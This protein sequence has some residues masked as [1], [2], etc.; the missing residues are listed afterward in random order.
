MSLARLFRHLPWDFWGWGGEEEGEREGG[1]RRGREKRR[2]W[3]GEEKGKTR[4]SSLAE[5]LE[6]CEPGGCPRLNPNGAQKA[7]LREGTRKAPDSRDPRGPDTLLAQ[8]L[9]S[10]EPRRSPFFP[11]LVQVEFPSLAI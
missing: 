6:K 9:A 5:K 8:D 3:K 7:G 2:K 10:H 1:S 4:P 11:K